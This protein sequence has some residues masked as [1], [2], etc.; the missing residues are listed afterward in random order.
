MLRR[1]FILIPAAWA[2][3]PGPS[4]AQED[5]PVSERPNVLLLLVDDLKPALGCYGDP[6]ARTPH[7]D[8][9][10]TRGL[11]FELAFCNQAVCAPSR[12]TLMLGAHSTVTGLYGL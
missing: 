8:N 12:F 10:A 3:F 9:L 11:R 1:A 2:L 5:Q 4:L 7:L 6:H